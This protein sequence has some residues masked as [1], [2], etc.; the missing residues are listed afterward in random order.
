MLSE[1]ATKNV[2]PSSTVKNESGESLGYFL[3]LAI[4]CTTMKPTASIRITLVT[5]RTRSDSVRPTSTAD[6]AIGMQDAEVAS[7]KRLDSGEKLP[8]ISGATKTL[9]EALAKQKR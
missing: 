5:F 2:L 6:R 4:T 1:L 3:R 9:Q 7:R 8:D